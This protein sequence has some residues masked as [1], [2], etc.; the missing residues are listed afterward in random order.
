MSAEE[1]GGKGKD[2]EERRER[3]KP[4]RVKVR[5]KMQGDKVIVIQWNLS[6]TQRFNTVRTKI[7]GEVLLFQKENNMYLYKVGTQS[8]VLIKQG[9]LIL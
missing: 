8:S 5:G 3:G 4:H 9:V 7:I 6:I 1:D 2:E